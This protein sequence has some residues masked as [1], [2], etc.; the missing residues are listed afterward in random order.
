M[1][2]KPISLI[3]I[4]W[5]LVLALVIILPAS[6]TVD[7]RKVE[8]GGGPFPFFG[9]IP[10]AIKRNRVYKTANGFIKEKEQYYDALRNTA[11]QQLLDREL[12]Y[13]LRDNQVAA[14]MKVI[15]LIEQERDAMYDFAESEKKAARD[16]FIDAIQD[17]VT[18]IMLTSAPAVRVL[19]AMAQGIDSSQGFLD[20]AINKLSGG[21]G[22]FLEEVAKVKRI[23]DR[24]TIVG[25]L[26]GGDFGRSI[27]KAGSNISDLVNKP[28]AEIESGLIQVQGELGALG[29]MVQD[30]QQ[31]GREPVASQTTRDVVIH[32]VTGESTNPAIEAIADMLVASR[33][34]NDFRERAKDIM[35]GTGAARCRAS[36]EKIRQVL[37]KLEVEPA[38]EDTTDI[39]D[40]TTC[41]AVDIAA[42]VE[43]VAA[44]DSAADDEESP[45]TDAEE[46]PQPSQSDTS[47]PDDGGSDATG[48]D[49]PEAEPFVST[50]EY[51]WVL[52]NTQTNTN[53]D[54][55][56]FYGG[57]QDPYYFTEERFKGK[58]LVFGCSAN[59]FTF[60]DVDVD[61]EYEFHNVTV[62]VDFD[63]PPTRLDSGQEMDLQ[64]FASSSGTI[65]EGG[66]GSGLR[67]QYH[68][69]NTGVEPVFTYFPWSEYFD[70]TTSWTYSLTA[71]MA[72]E[73]G[74]FTI[75]A[76]LWNAPPCHT[77]WTYQAQANENVPAPGD[78]ENIS[79]LPRQ[80]SP[81]QCREKQQEVASK[82]SIARGADTADLALGIIG[83]VTAQRGAARIDYCEGGEADS[84]KGIPIRIGDCLQTGSD[85]RVQIRLNDQDNKYNKGPSYLHMSTDSIMC[86]SNFS[87]H[88]DDGKPGLIDFLKG[89]IR[90][91]TEGWREGTGF[92][93]NVSIKAAVV[94]ASDVVLDYDPEH[95]LLRSY[96]NEG[97]VEITDISSG[98]SQLLTDGELLISPPGSIGSVERMS[99][100]VW[101]D[102]V[103]E[104]GLDLEEDSGSAD[105]SPSLART[106]LIIGGVCGGGLLV[107]G[108][109]GGFILYQRKK[110]KEE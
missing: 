5:R 21:G 45:A 14:Y 41:E 17:E 38:A 102:L 78:W 42:L 60:H 85:G 50:S 64:V 75:T 48:S 110:K 103:A 40:F 97:S 88:R 109:V 98:D 104:N 8:A 28:K 44:A 4:I 11:A 52:T 19:G 95:N 72:S 76:G 93:V 79:S 70:G 73:G 24:M 39:D 105:G 61:Y 7:V 46:A 9:L 32:L 22:G 100:R 57:G 80:Y 34:G 63:S 74:E 56:S 51:I 69:N 87:V 84:E 91:F 12:V 18:N 16:E 89:T 86:F 65:N 33:G 107:L 1:H 20:A 66:F 71:P 58:S 99:N 90:V 23:A 30:A 62:G 13:G 92:G 59:N 96:V 55:T 6:L 3:N 43:E 94:V 26:I 31:Q 82:V 77:V 35:L 2:R 83:Y 54:K 25:G 108:V 53:N 81:E 29:D 36:V 10:A 49:S 15:T 27:Q 67:F 37:F 106:A 68:L 47:P 101:K